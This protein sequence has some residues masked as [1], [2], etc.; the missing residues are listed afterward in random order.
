MKNIVIFIILI[1][2]LVLSIFTLKQSFGDIISRFSEFTPTEVVVPNERIRL[3]ITSSRKVTYGYETQEI[4]VFILTTDTSNVTGYT[5]IKASNK[6][7]SSNNLLNSGLGKYA[8]FYKIISTPASYTEFDANTKLIDLSEISITKDALVSGDLSGGT[9]YYI[10]VALM[11][12]IAYKDAI[13]TTN[14]SG[15]GTSITDPYCCRISNISW[16]S[17]FKYTNY[18]L[19]LVKLTVDMKMTSNTPKP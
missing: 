17:A 6:K 14:T 5:N 10:G 15:G 12:T 1:T 9:T 13:R 18:P 19:P 8:G 4:L 16:S 7:L 3:K 11:N 2:V